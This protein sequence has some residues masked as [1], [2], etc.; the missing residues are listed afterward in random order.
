MVFARPVTIWITGLP[1][2]GKSTLGIALKDRLKGLG[3]PVVMLDGD[4]VRN[5]LCADLGFSEADRAENIRRAA[6]VA[7]LLNSQGISA[8][9]CF[10][11]PLR[12]MRET[13]RNLVGESLFFEVFTDAP[14]EVCMLR[15]V[16]GNYARAATGLLPNFTGITAIYEKP[17][18]PSLCLHTDKLNVTEATEIL[19]NHFLKWSNA[20]VNKNDR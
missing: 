9:C 18:A 1:A 5:G 13:A 11:S 17:L 12:S 2:S 14:L 3:I 16:K 19:Y 15:D 10:V 20:E 7:A 6:H 8:I 4:E